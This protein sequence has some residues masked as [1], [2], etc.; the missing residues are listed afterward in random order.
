[1]LYMGDAAYWERKFAQRPP[2]ALPPDPQLLRD[3]PLLP[4]PG[5][6][7]DLACG[8]GRNLLLLARRGWQMTGVDASTQALSRLHSFLQEEGLSARTMQAD[9]SQPSFLAQLGRYR[10]IIINHYRLD[11]A[12]YAGLLSHLEPGGCLWVNGFRACPP[13]NPDIRPQD[14]LDPADFAALTALPCRRQDYDEGEKPFS[15][16]MFTQILG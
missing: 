4:Q 16:W 10:L 2:K 8:D 15:R 14:L 6:G 5:E 11:P 9:L 7:L 1:M 3:L 13:Q 12:L